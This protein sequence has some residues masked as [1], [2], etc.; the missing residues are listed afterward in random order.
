MNKIIYI[1]LFFLLYC[2]EQSNSSTNAQ[3]NKINKFDTIKY[4][5]KEDTIKKLFI[6]SHI[7]RFDGLGGINSE[8]QLENIKRLI[9]SKIDMI[10]V[11]IQITK[12]S[13][14]VLFHDVSLNTKT[15]G[16][17]RIQDKKFNQLLDIRYKSNKS[18]SISKLEDV[19][20][21]V[22]GTNTIIQLDKCDESEIKIIYQR[23]LF[24]GVENNILCKGKSFQIPEIVKTAG[25]MWMPIIPDKYVGKMTSETVIAE[26]VQKS[27]GSKFLEAQFS[28]YDKL[29]TNGY[30][31][32]ELNK[33]DCH[34]LIVAVGGSNLTNAKSFRGDNKTKWQK[35][36]PISGVI[37]T[38]Y[39]LSLKNL[40]N[41]YEKSKE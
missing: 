37:M 3:Y 33:I 6:C 27:K 38:N 32:K 1:L 21:Y 4:Y 34:L 18:A 35:M 23:G 25:L 19:L 30:L 28:D 31:N 17:G 26:I 24:K 36:I 16:S 40:L 2:C 5:Q 29:L 9:D 13:V 22:K 14:A 10:E 8:N 41:E 15:T 7:G 12:D 39:P 11:D 20:S